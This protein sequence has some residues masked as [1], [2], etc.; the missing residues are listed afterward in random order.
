LRPCLPARREAEGDVELEPREDELGMVEADRRS[1][2]GWRRPTGGAAGDGGGRQ[3]EHQGWRR[4]TGGAP[5]TGG[6]AQ[7]R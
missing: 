7:E 5:V 2:R 3:A 4:R 6:G 1:S